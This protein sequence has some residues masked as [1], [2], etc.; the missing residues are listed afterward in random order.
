MSIVDREKA[1]QKILDLIQ[2]KM[3]EQ[4]AKKR[5]AL[6]KNQQAL[7]SGNQAEAI[8]QEN[9][10]IESGDMKR[11]LRKAADKTKREF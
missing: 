5:E 11:I 9:K 4:E 10:T 7:K 8:A 2:A 1:K 6:Q 3:D